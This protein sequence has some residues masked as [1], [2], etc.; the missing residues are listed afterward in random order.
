MQ[1]PRTRLRTAGG[2]ATT[3]LVGRAGPKS[4][5]LSHL[6]AESPPIG[7]PSSNHLCKALSGSSLRAWTV[8]TIAGFQGEAGRWASMSPFG[9]RA[10]ANCARA[11]MMSSCWA[12]FRMGF[13]PQAPAKRWHEA[14][15]DA[16]FEGASSTTRVPSMMEG[17]L[18]TV[19]E[20]LRIPASKAFSS[21]CPRSRSDSPMTPRVMRLRTLPVR[22]AAR[23]R[24]RDL[25][26]R[27]T[28]TVRRPANSRSAQ[29]AGR[30]RRREHFPKPRL[31]CALLAALSR[32]QKSPP[33]T[34]RRTSSEASCKASC[35]P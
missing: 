20:G 14:R 16:M 27:P 7:A 10:D 29:R 28:P 9:S 12:G 25:V 33:A 26:G 8:A 32:A 31:L 18:A 21:R 22:G 3:A 5:P 15:C 17:R 11:E 1:H 24:T 2:S 30:P 4:V 13:C 23:G 34:K 35:M 6:H 19:P